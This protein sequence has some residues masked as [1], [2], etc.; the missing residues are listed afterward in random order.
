MLRAEGHPD[1]RGHVVVRL[2]RPPRDHDVSAAAAARPVVGNPRRRRT[3][4]L[5]G[6][7]VAPNQFF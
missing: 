5:A 6:M 1:Q 4:R 2:G 7:T 3:G